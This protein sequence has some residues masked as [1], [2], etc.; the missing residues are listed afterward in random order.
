MGALRN[1]V[2]KMLSNVGDGLLTNTQS[3]TFIQADNTQKPLHACLK[4]EAEIWKNS[5]KT[6][7]WVIKI[8]REQ[9]RT[10]INF[11]KSSLPLSFHYNFTSITHHL[12]ERTRWLLLF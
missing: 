11:F 3:L 2:A 5:S 7:V 9:E 4:S 6:T 8:H 1:N 12:F 10:V